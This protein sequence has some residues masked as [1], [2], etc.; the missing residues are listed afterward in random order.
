MWMPLAMAAIIMLACVKH[1]TSPAVD[2]LAFVDSF[3][4]TIP[5][6]MDISPFCR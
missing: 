4:P 6:G 2:A 5:Y 1:Q 3:N